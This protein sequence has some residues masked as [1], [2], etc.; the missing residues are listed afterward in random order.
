D[1]DFGGK[2]ITETRWGVRFL[3]VAA[4]TQHHA[5]SH[6][7]SRVLTF[8]D[9][10]DKLRADVYLHEASYKKNPIGWY[11]PAARTFPLRHRFTTPRERD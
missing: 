5:G 7:L 1:D 3:Q 10:S 6:P 9:G 11:E 8:T 4:L 2:T